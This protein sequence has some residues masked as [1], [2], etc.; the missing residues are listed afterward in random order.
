MKKQTYII[1]RWQTPV[2]PASDQS[3]QNV[4]RKLI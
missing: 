3:I 4:E 1:P 2:V